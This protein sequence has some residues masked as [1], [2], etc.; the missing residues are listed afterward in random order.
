MAPPHAPLEP[1]PAT[2]VLVPRP[3]PISRLSVILARVE[4]FPWEKEA[5][6]RSAWTDWSKHPYLLSLYTVLGLAMW[7]ALIYLALKLV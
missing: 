2:E 1:Q 4:R 3:F 5:P 6:Q 7:G